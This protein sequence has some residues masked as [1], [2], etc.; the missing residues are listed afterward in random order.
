MSRQAAPLDQSHGSPIPSGAR[1][2]GRLGAH[3]Q[4]S[5][6]PIFDLKSFSCGATPVLVATS[7]PS[8]RGLPA[9]VSHAPHHPLV[10][11]P[12]ERIRYH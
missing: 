1:Q 6:S 9:V 11:D 5:V 8:G 10:R 2:C 3:D 12:A 7:T 4:A